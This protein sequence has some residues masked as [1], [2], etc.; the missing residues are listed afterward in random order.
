MKIAFIHDH[1]LLKSKSQYYTSGGLG[2]EN[3][4][5]KYVKNKLSKLVL[6]TRFKETS[7]IK[8][9]ILLEDERLMINPSTYYKTPMDY[10]KK[11]NKIKAEVKELL[12]DIDFCVIRL[13]SVLGIIAYKEAKRMRVRVFI[14]LVGCP[15][16]ALMNYGGIKGY[17]FMPVMYFNTKKIVKEAKYVH[18]VTSNFLQKRYPTSGKSVGCSDVVINKVDEINLKN[19]IDKINENKDKYIFGIVGSLNVNYKGHEVSI[20]ALS[21]LKDKINFELHFLGNGD[22]ERWIKLAKK[23]NIEENIY[24]DGVLPSGEPVM[25]W[26]DNLDIHLIM[27]KQ[28]GMPRILIEAMSRA[29]IS[30]GSNVGGIPELLDNDCLVEKNDF[31]R[32]ASKIYKIINDKE[33]QVE[34]ANRNFN[35]SKE[36]TCD[37]LY[38]IRKKFYDEFLEENLKDE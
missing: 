27:S 4:V 37:K 5:N 34:I 3:F 20:K 33:Y 26:L 15:Y 19:R 1:V 11:L 31:K 38:N 36:Y 30:I 17:L 24:F 12:K 23:Y 28:E 8:N 6:Y 10:F 7:D 32:L 2:G 14:E 22:K 18:Y 29:S 13:P 25:K 9:K 35:K 16:D 21:L